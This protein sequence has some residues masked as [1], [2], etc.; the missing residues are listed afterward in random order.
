M[1]IEGIFN[2]DGFFRLI[3]GHEYEVFVMLISLGTS[4]I[5]SSVQIMHLS[6]KSDVRKIDVFAIYVTGLMV[7]FLSYGVTFYHVSIFYVATV[8]VVVSYMSLD[9]FSAAKKAFI[10]II[11]FI[12]DIV[13]TYFNS[14]IK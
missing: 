13:K 9:F 6:L 8:S 5:G 3:Y 10:A 1:T 2:W 4:F 11:G 12:P 7:G 14:K